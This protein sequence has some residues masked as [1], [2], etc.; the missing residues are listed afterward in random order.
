LQVYDLALRTDA[1][2]PIAGESQLTYVLA[3]ETREWLLPLRRTLPV[4]VPMLR[5][6]A[7][8]DAGEIDASVRLDP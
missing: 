6:N 4:S 7:F 5:L 3:G 8:T 1:A 2:E